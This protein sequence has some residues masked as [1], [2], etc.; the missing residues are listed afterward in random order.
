MAKDDWY[1]VHSITEEDNAGGY[2]VHKYSKD[3][4]HRGA[5][6]LNKRL[7]S[8]DCPAHVLY[9]RHKQIVTTF[10]EAKRIGTGWLYSHDKKEWKEPVKTGLEDEVVGRDEPDLPPAA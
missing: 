10:I 9:C 2:V 5:Y 6:E 3:G 4:D 8:C 7:S 1:T